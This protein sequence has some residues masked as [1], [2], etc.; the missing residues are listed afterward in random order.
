MECDTGWDLALPA[1]TSTPCW[2][3]FTAKII[4]AG[5]RREALLDS[6]STISMVRA[7]LVLPDLPMLRW[8]HILCFSNHPHKWSIKPIPTTVAGWPVILEAVCVTQLPYPALLGRDF[9]AFRTLLHEARAP[10]QK[11]AGNDH[12]GGV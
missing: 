7:N 5:L 10:S 3:A 8:T 12:E 2:P 4:L 1:T 11:L 6:G 9:P